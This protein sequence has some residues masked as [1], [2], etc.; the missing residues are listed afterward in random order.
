MRTLKQ[1]ILTASMCCLMA[2]ANATPMDDA[3]ASDPTTDTKLISAINIAL[4]SI[5]K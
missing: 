2:T 5:Q 1:L 4:E 3:T